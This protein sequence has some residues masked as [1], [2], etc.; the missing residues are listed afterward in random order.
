[1]TASVFPCG[2]RLFAYAPALPYGF[3]KRV[4]VSP[5]QS[6]K[7]VKASSA[8]ETVGIP[9]RRRNDADAGSIVLPV[10]IDGAPAGPLKGLTFVVKDLFDVAGEKTSFGNPEWARTHDIAEETAPVI[11]LLL[12]AGAS[13]RGKAIMDELAYSLNGENVHF[14][15]PIN[16]AAPDRI[17][18]GSSSGSAAAVA[19]SLVDFS[20]GT[21]TAGSVRVPASF[22]GLF[23]MRPTH[24]RVSLHGARPLAASFDTCG[25]FARDA[26]TLQVVGD[27]LLQPHPHSHPQLAA[28]KAT[29]PLT[30]V[31]R[32]IVATDAMGLADKDAV[33]A[34]YAAL[35]PHIGELRQAL[36][37][38]N[39][40]RV[41]TLQGEGELADWAEKFRTLQMREI[42]Q[43]HGKW[44]SQHNP[45]FGPGIKQRI[46]AASKVT[47]E[48]SDAAAA[49][50]ARIRQHLDTLLAEVPGT[51][52]CLPTATGPAPKK[53]TPSEELESFRA[54]LFTLTVMAGLGGYPQVTIPVATC[55][56]AP[57]GLSFVAAR[58]ADHLLLQVAATVAHILGIS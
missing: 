46:E 35:S 38:P 57:V 13:L 25:W 42:W 3:R 30:D 9:Q 23:G 10:C 55:Q 53:G 48:Q 11:Q 39:E 8:T 54:R 5:V 17:P 33:D 56:G 27:V 15:T 2:S 12:D 29:A 6:L 31:G 36:G 52:L 45:G 28:G 34:L 16:S 26:T 32:W 47:K 4:G 19:A 49:A 7:K 1:M 37:A 50:R 14:G 51:I 24:G 22:C 43:A 44:I 20:L 21:D 58:N 41:A 18:G 40:M